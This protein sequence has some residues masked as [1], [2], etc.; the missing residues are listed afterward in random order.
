[1]RQFA[2]TWCHCTIIN[3]FQAAFIIAGVFYKL[4]GMYGMTVL[5]ATIQP[6]TN[7]NTE[8]LKTKTL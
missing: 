3:T 8:G 7:T 4:L 6:N 5:S 2:L 1:M